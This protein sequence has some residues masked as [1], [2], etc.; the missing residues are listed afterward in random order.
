MM[1][2]LLYVEFVG[3]EQHRKI[4]SARL[5]FLNCF[6]K[7]KQV[8]QGATQFVDEGYLVIVEVANE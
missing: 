1:A 5:H 2:Y 8:F 6:G 3:E 4:Y 7:E